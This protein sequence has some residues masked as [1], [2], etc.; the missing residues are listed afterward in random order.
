V[1]AR[2]IA[3]CFALASLT[4]TDGHGRLPLDAASGDLYLRAWGHV[5]AEYGSDFVEWTV[6]DHVSL[7]GV[8]E[9]TMAK[10][11]EETDVSRVDLTGAVVQNA[12]LS[13]R[14][15]FGCVLRGSDLRFAN[16]SDAGLYGC[17]LSNADLRGA[18]LT[19]ALI[20]GSELD[21]AILVGVDLSSTGFQSTD[22]RRAILTED[23]ARAR[24]VTLRP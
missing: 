18:I 21:G 7:R 9:A 4:S 19:R 1:V 5:R 15:L 14:L 24:G 2:S 17:D 6:Q 22:L 20:V 8:S 23:E 13:R 16:L 10:I 11:V 3:A 12:D